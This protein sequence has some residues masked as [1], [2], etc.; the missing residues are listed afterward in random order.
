L[1]ENKN[2]ISEIVSWLDDHLDSTW[3]HEKRDDVPKGT[4]EPPPRIVI[5]K[6]E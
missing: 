5:E 4:C 3:D 6:V 1:F 2:A